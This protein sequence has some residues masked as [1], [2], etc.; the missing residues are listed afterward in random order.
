M[1][2]RLFKVTDEHQLQRLN[3]LFAK[4]GALIFIF[5][6]AM[7]Y[8]EVMFDVERAYL[9]PYLIGTI[10]CIV[11][12]VSMLVTNGYSDT[13]KE[14]YVRNDNEKKMLNKMSFI[15]RAI[16][17]I[18]AFAYLYLIP[19]IIIPILIGN[20]MFG[21]QPSSLIIFIPLIV[22][23]FTGDKR[24]KVSDKPTAPVKEKINHTEPLLHL[25]PQYHFSDEYERMR[26]EME[27][28]KN[29]VWLVISLS[30]ISII[31]IVIE[32]VMNHTPYASIVTLIFNAILIIITTLKVISIKKNN[33][34]Q[35]A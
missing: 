25:I 22:F 28:A 14:I 3:R 21:F 19:N 34:S 30:L 32:I 24:I 20:K 15:K 33:I 5:L 18:L 9:S 7:F 31:D 35:K 29:F 16:F 12:L 23:I 26:I 17:L 13:N 4:F 11:V 10:L 6:I 2:S 8:F 27:Y 1:I